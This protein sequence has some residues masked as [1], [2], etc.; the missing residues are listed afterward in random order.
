MTVFCFQND[1][2]GS[3]VTSGQPMFAGSTVNVAARPIQHGQGSRGNSALGVGERY[4]LASFNY[5]QF[6]LLFVVRH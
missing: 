5:C 2:N 3:M 6:F 1:V 4:D